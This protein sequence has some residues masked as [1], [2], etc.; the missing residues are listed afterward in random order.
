MSAREIAAADAARR[1]LDYLCLAQLYLQDNLLLREPLQAEHVIE[2]PS[3]HWG[4]CPP[5]NAVLAALGTLR[6][7][8]GERIVLHGAGHAGPAA[9]AHAWLTGLLGAHDPAYSRDAAGLHRLIDGFRERDRFGTEITPLLPE[10]HYMGGQ[11]GPTLAVA[12]GMALD[13]P[14][15]LVVVL[16]GD[17]E[18]ETGAAT[19]AWLGAHALRETGHHGRVLPVVLL[20]GMRM[21]GPSLLAKLG[22]DRTAAWLDGLGYTPIITADPSTTALRAAL[23]QG[24]QQTCPVEHGPGPAVLVTI[25][26]GYG[27]PDELAGSPRLHKTPL[28]D[29]RH[30]PWELE[31]LARWLQHYRPDQLFTDA[32]QPCAQVHAGLG[33]VR[34]STITRPS[35]ESSPDGVAAAHDQ[36]LTVREAGWDFGTAMAATLQALHQTWSI[37]VFSPDELASNRIDLDEPWSAEVLNEELCHLWAQGLADTG[38]RAVVVSYEAFAPIVTSL[39]GQHLLARRLAA[40]AGRSTLPSITYLLT[41]LGWNNTVSHAN[42]ALTDALLATDDPAVHVYTPADPART[43]AALTVA[44]TAP[45]CTSL[46]VAS[47]HP[48]T[49]HP[50]ETL[51]TE[52]THGYAIWPH[53]SDQHPELVLVSAGDI[54]ATELVAA[55]QLLRTTRPELRLRYVHVHDMTCLGNPRTWPMGIPNSLFDE[56][57]PPAIPMLAATTSHAAALHALLGPRGQHRPTVIRGWQPVAAPLGPEQLRQHAGLDAATLHDTALDLLNTRPHTEQS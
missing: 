38:R 7:P 12:Q 10:Q 41:S 54:A 5:V 33:P 25:P 44:V 15:R 56:V 30:T 13:A 24:L 22:P 8:L 35:T 31:Q 6:D 26:K 32:G 27:A 45:G 42:P 16:I 49:E 48:V 23:Q 2:T 52:L 40:T 21:G 43:A 28:R 20:N 50:L 55:A 34:P 14:R 3:G 19:A 37:R 29:P 39:I 11:L 53:L 57:F 36:A 51:T 9:R 18:L 47:K 46:V 1:A 17:G 4:V